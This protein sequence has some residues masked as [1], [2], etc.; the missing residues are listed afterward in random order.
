MSRAHGCSIDDITRS[1]GIS[2]KDLFTASPANLR[3]QSNKSPFTVDDFS[4]NKKLPVEFLTGHGLLNSDGGVKITYLDYDGKE[5]VRQRLRTSAIANEGSIW[6]GTKGVSPDIYGA[7]RLDGF[8]KNC[9]AIL[10]VEGES[11]ALTA[12][13]HGIAALG[14]PGADMSKTLKKEYLE[15]FKKIHILVEPDKGGKTFL[16]RIT[17]KLKEFKWPGEAFKLTMPDGTKDLNELHIKHSDKNGFEFIL[18]SCFSKSKKVDTTPKTEP[19][20]LNLG[21]RFNLTD[22]GNA[23]RLVANFGKDIRYSYQWNRWLVWDG[24]RWKVDE[25]GEIIRKA[26]L[27]IRMI[28]GEAARE[29]DSEIRKALSNH[30]RKSEAGT[31]I[32]EMIRLTQSEPGIAI[33]TDQLDSNSWLFNIENG[34][35]NLKT[36]VRGVHQREDLITKLAPVTWDRDAKCPRWLRF[37]LQI[38]KKNKK[39]VR[40]IQRSIGYGLTG[41]VSE[42]CL[43]FLYGTGANGKSVLLNL[44]STMMGDYAKQAESELLV[45][46]KH[47]AHPTGIADLFGARFVSSTEVGDG[48]RMNET[49]VKQLTGDDKV[50]ARFMHQN[51]FEFYSTYKIFLAANHKPTI[52][53][54]DYA[55]WRRLKLVPFEVTFDINSRNKNLTSELKTEMPGILSWAV[56]GCLEWQR[57]GLGDPPEITQ[58]GAKYRQE[59]DV[60]GTFI[61]DCCI[62][63]DNAMVSASSVYKSYTSWCMDNGERALSQRR[64]GGSLTERGFQRY[65]GGQ[66]RWQWSGIGLVTEVTDGD[67]TSTFSLHE[68][69]N[70][71]QTRKSSEVTEVQSPEKSEWEPV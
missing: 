30:A 47:E 26:K 5:S 17:D 58:A 56:Q 9:V 60:I 34:T 21:S 4:S 29:P 42:Q 15:G 71:Q 65:R 8:K 54:T 48:K 43:F 62:T 24:A 53:G 63:I 19:E 16:K 33:I 32:S 41:N 39:M 68:E 11:D 2:L 13:Y 69:N 12:W 55:I 36:G 6:T 3:V 70:V 7:W 45:S 20:P 50:K 66:G 14:I 59:M 27:T 40:F 28:Y 49:L 23:Q 57:D 67:L 35:I 37:M 1:I 25:T 61:S 22:Y 46:K 44:I 51:F 31:R 64:F 38:M 52:R 18:S 10:L